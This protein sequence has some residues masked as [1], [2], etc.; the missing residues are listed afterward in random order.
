MPSAFL[1]ILVILILFSSCAEDEIISV[2]QNNDIHLTDTSFL[3][4]VSPGAIKLAADLAGYPQFLP[5][6]KY[7]IELYKIEY[8]TTYRNKDII[9]SGVISYPVNEDIIFPIMLV[10]NGLIFADEDAP[11]SFK[12]PVRYTGFEFIGSMGYITLI[13]DMIGFGESKDL[14][15]PIHNY[16]YSARTMIDFFYA[17]QEFIRDKNL[18]AGSKRF[19]TGYSQGAYIALST[20]KMIESNPLSGIKISA[21]AIGAGGFNLLDLFT[22]FMDE[23][24]YTAPSHLAIL[25]SSYNVIYDWNRPLSDFFQEPYATMIPELLSGSLNREEIDAK[26]SFHLDS[27]LN[28]QFITDF[29]NGN[30]TSLLQAL[31]ENSI[32][33]WAPKGELRIIHSLNDERIPVSDSQY[34]YEQMLNNGAE[35]VSLT[36]IDTEGHINS[37]LE[38]IEMIIQWFDQKKE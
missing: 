19:L 25:L 33:D 15:Y 4:S 35:N 10:G 2:P 12:F 23:N 34:T 30:E 20:L 16:E 21:T 3:G 6:F 8:H 5:Y 1:P 13:P 28:P 24:Y 29:K 14:I 22:S 27:L 26:L 9:A 31:A 11:S 18:K 32:A 38:F 17:A 7:S 37:G 36:I